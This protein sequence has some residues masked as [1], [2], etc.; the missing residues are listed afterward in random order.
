MEKV[1]PM[2]L[3]EHKGVQAMEEDG[4]RSAKITYAY[5]LWPS[6]STSRNLSKF[7]LYTYGTMLLRGAHCSL[8]CGSETVKIT[9]DYSEGTG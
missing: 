6:H 7:I 8:L 5:M 9:Q 4:A 1:A 3:T 2:L